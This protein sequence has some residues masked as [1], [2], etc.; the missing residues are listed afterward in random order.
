[1][2]EFKKALSKK[3]HSNVIDQDV[4]D[5][6]LDV[7]ES[8][9]VQAPAG[10]G[11]TELLTQRIL[12]LLSVVSRP[13]NILAITFTRK[14][15]SE[16][17]ERV[18]SALI[19]AENVS[20]APQTPHELARWSLAK[21]VL[22]RDKEKQWNLIANPNRLKLLTID[23][24]SANLTGALPLLSQTG[25]L[26]SIA[27]NADIYFKQASQAM[28]EHIDDDEL[29]DVSSHI[30]ILL[31]HKDNNLKQLVD[32]VSQLL[33][34]RLQWLPRISHSDIE[35][36]FSTKTIKNSLERIVEEKLLDIY[37][38]MPLNIIS[39]LPPL[40]NQ[41]S[42]QLQEKKNIKHLQGLDIVESIL[43]PN[44][45][46]LTLWKAIAELLLTASKTKPSFYKSATKTN[47]FP[48]PAD[49]IND[50]QENEFK[51]NKEMMKNILKDCSKCTN[52]EFIVNEVRYLP[53]VNHGFDSEV[54]ESLLAIL[55]LAVAHLK[56]VFKE[57]N[58]L[59]F[60]ELSIASLN[61]LGT[62]DNPTDIALAMDYR[63]EHILVDEF[64]DTSSPQID[65]LK[66]LTSG[67]DYSSNKT[68]FLVGDPMQSIYRFRDANVSLFMHIAEFGIGQVHPVYKQLKV[69]FR[70]N[71]NII[72]WV[73]RQFQSIMPAVNDL[74]LSAVSYATS[75]AFRKASPTSFVKSY[76]TVDAEDN[77]DQ[78][79]EILSVIQQHL[80]ENEKNKSDSSL[81]TLAILAR[82][83]NH[84]KEIIFLLN[85]NNIP[86]QAIDIEPLSSKMAVQDVVSLALALTDNYDQISWLACLRSPWFSLELDDMTK[87]M[88]AMGLKNHTIL[89]DGLD[90]GEKDNED[91]DKNNFLLS[92]PETIN[93]LM[94]HH[95]L[96]D[97]LNYGLS[98]G[99]SESG[100]ARCLKLMPILMSAIEQKGKKPFQKWLYGCFEAVGGLLQ[101][102]MLSEVEDI[103]TCVKRIAEFE[104]AGEIIDRAGLQE[105]LD[106][107]YASPNSSADNQIQIM[108][109][110][111]SKG[112]EFDRVILPRL[113]AKSFVPDTPLMK[114]AE[115]ISDVG[116]SQTLLAISKPTGESNDSVYEYIGY[117][118][119]QKEKYENQRLLYVATTR[120][121]QELHLF[122]NIKEDAKKIK[123]GES[124]K[125]SYK[126]PIANSFLDM[127]WD[128]IEPDESADSNRVK[129][130]LNI[131]KT[132]S[133]I[134]G[135]SKSDDNQSLL[136]IDKPTKLSEYELSQLTHLETK[137]QQLD[138]IFPD[139][140]TKRC[141]I[142]EVEEMPRSSAHEQHDSLEYWNENLH[143]KNIASSVG[144]L[145]HR[146]LEWIAEDIKRTSQNIKG[147]SLKL[148]D[149]YRLPTSWVDTTKSQLNALNLGINAE[150][151][152]IKANSI[153]ELL[154]AV[155]KSE[156]GQFILAPYD[157]A[158]NELALHK[159][160]G[161]GLFHSRVI[162]RCFITEG[163]RWIIDYKSSV[164]LKSET[165]EEFIVRELQVYKKQ[166][167]EYVSFFKEMEN[168]PTTAGLYLLSINQ[169]VAV[170]K[171]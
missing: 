72:D 145:I 31:K 115:V 25:M 7:S 11:K 137:Q 120:A 71:E 125:N 146:Q 49:A 82:S 45:N 163:R 114:W 133:G 62:E 36:V 151:I 9:I 53:D 95:S 30:K 66:L 43:K 37:S 51:I 85:K 83:R 46:D 81:K 136:P 103:K 6:L 148:S 28:L 60:S 34:K 65:L 166:L 67:W 124:G 118:D 84:L 8:Y 91:Y 123:A 13:E 132:V 77:Q 39:E 156:I 108:T 150:Q 139:R 107:L 149:E 44:A 17:K 155:I 122:G 168:Y 164:P 127:I 167:E 26:P 80:L 70:S 20:E 21:K 14:A 153:K 69:N 64:Q 68:L 142:S 101:I 134:C 121:K 104:N 119:K 76:L 171:S 16:M 126:R 1:M 18:I 113:D 105:S 41:A 74:T 59:D 110:H 169:F 131:I 22:E 54:L 135:N 79:N 87:V 102:D 144:T 158:D 47:G 35:D 12:A 24:L 141:D 111:K 61:A 106:K 57:H 52:L 15:A 86:Y 98:K 56:L 10:S 63:I 50:D 109:I 96:N 161:K 129:Q 112:L 94:T 73:N 140:L 89:N 29:G 75:T 4:R 40:L 42:S 38:A 48:Q 55:P 157:S 97:C 162:D 93:K 159:N 90:S 152:F 170:Y 143:E 138:V 92:I 19:F 100:K 154:D 27:E 99:L 147:N 128:N 23:S 32:L 165:V 88:R 58:V 117:L 5:E 33:A 116:G 130:K 78:A 2:S 3:N 160:L